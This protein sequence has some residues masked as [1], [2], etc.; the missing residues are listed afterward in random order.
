MFLRHWLETKEIIYY[1]RYVENI[2]IIFDQDKTNIKTITDFM[3]KIHP[4]LQSEPTREEYNTITY[5]DLTTHRHAHHLELGIHRKTT[6]TDSTIHYTFNHPPQHKLA[7]YYF[8]TNRMLSLPI[9]NQATQ[10]EWHLIRTIAMNNGFPIDLIHKLKNKMINT[11]PT[12]YNTNHTHKKTWITFT[13]HSPLIH[14]VTNLF[15]HTNINITF[16]PTNTIYHLLH[17]KPHNNSLQASEIY[18][19]QCGTC[20]KSY[21]RQSDRSII[22]R[23]REHTRYIRTNNPISAFALHILN[24]AHEYGPPEQTLHLLHPCEKGNSMNHWETFH[25]QQLHH[26][27][28]L[29]DQQQPPEHNPLY[30][31]G[32]VTY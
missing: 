6:Q 12:Q 21:V 8:Y 18:Q 23:Y 15:K 3:N 1:R 22:T 17:N 9:T 14:N 27:N 29:T 26:L 28:Q 32:S 7:A 2:L 10:Q 20:N 13:Y 4:H 30:T 24:N 16:S 11:P 19:L 31:L 25:M 5:L